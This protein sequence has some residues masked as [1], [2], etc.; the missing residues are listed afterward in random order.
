MNN[1]T[2]YC[3]IAHWF[4]KVKDPSTSVFIRSLCIFNNYLHTSYTYCS[5]STCRLSC[6]RSSLYFCKMNLLKKAKN[7]ICLL[8]ICHFESQ[9]YNAVKKNKFLIKRQKAGSIL[10]NNTYFQFSRWFEGRRHQKL[11]KLPPWWQKNLQ[12]WPGER[13]H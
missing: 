2:I 1:L 10:Q 12:S 13:N 3:C 8:S 7:D 11:V 5:S 4:W 9:S 6:C